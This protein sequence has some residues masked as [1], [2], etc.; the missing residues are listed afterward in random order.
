MLCTFQGCVDIRTTSYPKAWPATLAKNCDAIGG[1]YSNVSE[2]V[3]DQK[4]SE[5]LFSLIGLLGRSNRPGEQ[6]T[7]S[8]A[9]TAL[10]VASITGKHRVP[11]E[12]GVRPGGQLTCQDGT[13]QLSWSRGIE[14]AG[15][16][17]L[18]RART[19]VFLSKGNDGTL[20]VRKERSE[21]GL[22]SWFL[23]YHRR[24]MEWYRFRP[25]NG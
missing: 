20:I 8:F 2:P 3:P 15:A 21:T 23:P 24:S 19:D 16:E 1:T 12:P 5:T 10:E 6:I 4:A 14:T 25:F 22:Y 18:G 11:D 13:V 17:G 7:I 9:P